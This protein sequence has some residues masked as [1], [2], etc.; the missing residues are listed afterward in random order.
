MANPLAL[1][2]SFYAWFIKAALQEGVAIP[3]VLPTDPIM[4]SMVSRYALDNLKE[5]KERAEYWNNIFSDYQMPKLTEGVF[6]G[7]LKLLKYIFK[8]PTAIKSATPNDGIIIRKGRQ[9]IQKLKRAHREIAGVQRKW[10]IYNAI[11]NVYKELDIRA[12]SK[13]LYGVEYEAEEEELLPKHRKLGV[14]KRWCWL[15]ALNPSNWF[16]P[17]LI[18]YPATSAINAL[19]FSAAMVVWL[20]RKA[21]G[22]HAARAIYQ[23]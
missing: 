8:P 2:R 7:T 4:L 19:E 23:E 1:S 9:I 21:F 17:P 18:E 15:V 5:N 6:S 10:P 20:W 3:D 14:Y 11:R 12:V 16:V 22:E 13:A